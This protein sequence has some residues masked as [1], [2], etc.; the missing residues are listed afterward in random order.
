MTKKKAA[1]APK[2]TTNKTKDSLVK[3]VVDEDKGEWLSPKK[4]AAFEISAE[5]GFPEIVFKFKTNQPPPFDWKW[6]IK[7]DAKVSGLKESAKR[8]ALLKTFEEKGSFSGDKPE[9]RA[10]VGKIV[11]GRLTV[12]VRAG[13]EVFRRSVEVKA[14]NPSAD[15]IKAFL[16]KQPDAAGFDRLLEQESGF[17]HLINADGQPVVA[18]DKG[19]G[20]TQMTNPA[21]SF[22]QVWNWKENLLAGVKLYQQKQKLAKAF[23][24]QSKR[25]YTDEQLKLETWSRWN[26]GGYHTWDA[27]TKSWV[28]SSTTLCDTATGNIGWDTTEKDNKGKTESE[29]HERDKGTYANPKKDKTEANKWRYTGVCY[30]DHVNTE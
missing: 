18:F 22:E 5:P 21:P 27:E 7:W 28:R 16:A 26:G 30:A 14:K 3:V 23:L 4:D 12:E 9:W 8:G 24:S 10:D 6:E 25:T 15:D 17:K 29:L 20:L 1:Q 19:Y 13:E 11:G 2:Q